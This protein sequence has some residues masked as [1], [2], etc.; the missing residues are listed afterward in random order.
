MFFAITAAA[1]DTSNG[2]EVIYDASEFDYL[3]NR[4]KEDVIEQYSEA[5]AAGHTYMNNDP[6]SYYNTP[7]STVYPYN[8]GEL[9]SDT[10]EAMGAMSNF[11]RWLLGIDP[12]T[13]NQTS[14]SRMQAEALLRNFEFAHYISESSRPAD[15]DD[16]TWEAGFNCTH[17]ILARG[18]TPSAAITGWLNEGYSLSSESWGTVGHR[19]AIL[20]AG[21][22]NLIYGFSG[23]VA[24]GKVQSAGNGFS[25]AFAAFPA[26]GYMPNSLCRRYDSAWTVQLNTAMVKASD[27]SGVVVKVTNMNTGSSYECT[28]SNQWASV[29][30]SFVCFRQPSDST[31]IYDSFADPYKVEITGLTDVASGKAAKIC[32]TVDFFEMEAESSFLSSA[33]ISMS[34][35]D[36]CYTGQAVIPEFTVTYKGTELTEGT[37]Y[38]VEYYNNTNVGTGIVSVKGK[39]QYA[40]VTKAL[41][42]IREDTKDIK[43]CNIAVAS[44]NYT[45][46]GNAHTPKVT[47][48]EF[49]E[50]LEEDKDYQITYSDNI[51]A[52]QATITVTGIGEYH[53]T[54]VRSFKINKNRYHL[55]FI[56]RPSEIEKG[57]TFQLVCTGRGEI[58]YQSSDESIFTVDEAGLVTG[59][60]CGTAKL[61][62]SASGDEN[63]GTDSRIINITV[64]EDVHTME[65]IQT[66]NGENNTAKRKCI[67][68]GKE[69]EFTTMTDFEVWWWKD[70]FYNGYSGISSNQKEG[71]RYKVTIR[72]Q[73]PADVEDKTLELISSDENIMTVNDTIFS[74]SGTG[75]VTLTIRAKYNPSVQKQV[76]FTV[77]HVYDGVDHE[78]AP[79]CTEAGERVSI[80]TV[81]GEEYKEILPALGHKEEVIPGKAATCTED[82]LTDGAKCSVC[83]EI[84]LEQT[85]IPAAGHQEEMIP[86]KAATC[87]ESGLTDGKK[88]SV[89]GEILVLQN[90]IPALGHKEAV[91]PAKAA[92]CTESGL[93]EGKKCSVCGEI[94][95][96]QEE[97]PALG[98]KEAVIPGKAA[99]C[100]ESGLTEGRKCSVCN[101]TLI[102]Q[103]VIPALGHKEETIPGK[104]ATCTEDGLTDGAKCSVCG[105]IL[106]EQT[107]IFAS[108][109][110]PATYV[111]NEIPPT[112]D[113]EGSCTEVIRCSVCG[114]EYGR[115]TVTIPRNGWLKKENKWYFFHDNT[116]VKGWLDDNGT[117]Y[118]L[119]PETGEMKT[120]WLQSGT[121]WYYLKSGGAMATGWEKVGNDWYYFKT[122][123]AM[124]TGWYNDSGIWY[125]LNPSGAMVKGWQKISGVW[126]YMKPSGAMAASEWCLGYWLNANGSWTY[127][128]KGSW[129][130]TDNRWWFGDTSGW[131]ARNERL[132]I[133]GVYYQFDNAGY[134]VQ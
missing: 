65:V 38:D 103:T 87:T 59:V 22:K 53:G 129:A 82:G 109:H 32:Y 86:G 130:K 13:V 15:M 47:V 80:C 126:Y 66:A 89:C 30:S 90:V 70:P 19:K 124:G 56:S 54:A 34:R 33:S 6:A 134:L 96:A 81:C 74:F 122:S 79:T 72:G 60:S 106:L 107:V 120:G 1:D 98:H 97:V 83:G 112:V 29:S 67:V 93:K 27:P 46:S 75:T 99:T 68:C 51:N 39:G 105:E 35:T 23:Y 73:S 69:E 11:Y 24:I 102:E 104:A 100:T 133:D 118:Y 125:Y 14:D 95:I 8:A 10:L 91:L 43:D 36:Y 121:T 12:I 52:G 9:S 31:S 5:M 77:S 42:T 21:Y 18:F 61:T 117:W 127:Q 111:E 45:Y 7:A 63:Y 25:N 55:V 62:V 26:A 101:E 108:G 110:V 16:E 119:N 131:Y 20:T 84:L 94:L 57:G 132:L 3:S 58:T 88:C 71:N 115:Q 40:G 2:D 4:T 44:G 50:T 48:T 128:P 78:T 17:N 76:T 116:M 92:T 49:G 114:E 85:V 64:S 123:G 41:F 37:D 113:Q 28:S